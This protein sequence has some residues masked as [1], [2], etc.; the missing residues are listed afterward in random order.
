MSATTGADR[1]W[2]LVEDI[3]VCMLTSKAGSA[4]RARPMHA[5]PDVEAGEIVFFADARAHKDDEIA[6][7]PDVCLAFAK[8]NA[9]EYVSLSGTAV[10]SNDRAEIR[11]RFNETT[12]TWF[13]D[14]PEDPNIRL[15]KVTPH[16]GEYWD[17]V[18]NPLAVAF[19]V[20]RARMKGERPDLSTN[21]KVALG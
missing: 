5:M 14:G 7:D 2:E 11:T 18:S 3:G 8:P 13:P 4:L 17:G 10:V 19:E 12:K 1:V 6:A 21:R 20:A 15:L 16:E 9:N